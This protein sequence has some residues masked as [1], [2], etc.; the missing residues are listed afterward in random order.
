VVVAQHAVWRDVGSGALAGE[1]DLAS[2]FRV[3][4]GKVAR[5]AR[6]D[7]LD[8]ALADGGLT[9]ADAQPQS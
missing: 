1:A 5:F 2:A 3:G 9:V 4:D 7:T 6:H 8:A